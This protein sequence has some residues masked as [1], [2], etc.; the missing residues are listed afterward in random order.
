MAVTVR[1][2]RLAARE[3]AKAYRWYWKRSPR[4]AQ[5]FADAIDRA[6]QEIA[7][8]PDRWPVHQGPYRWFRPRRFPYTLYYRILDADNVVIVAIAHDRRRPNYWMR[9][10]RP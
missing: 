2:L 1:H 4:V 9:R 3:Y 6:I 5:Q 8:A 10:M 7:N